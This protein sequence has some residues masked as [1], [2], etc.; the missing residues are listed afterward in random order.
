MSDT[1]R[2]KLL[3]SLIGGAV[4][5]AL[6]SPYEFQVRDTYDVSREYVYNL[7]FDIPAGAFTDD[8]SMMLCLAE[9]LTKTGGFYGRD[10]MERYAKWKY[11]G[12]MSS[13]PDKGCFDIG[14]A[15]S[16]AI[17]KYVFNNGEMFST[18]D[19]YLVGHGHSG[20]GGIMRLAPI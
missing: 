4:G 3:G 11:R 9:S 14:C 16:E 20:N 15:T 19:D 12:Y 17:S 10:Q 2:N 1:L 13:V 6:G 8:T 5:D 18:D 7:T